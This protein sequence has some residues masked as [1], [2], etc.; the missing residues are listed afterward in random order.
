MTICCVASHGSTR[1]P[2]VLP[3]TPVDLVLVSPS[4]FPSSLK[5]RSPQVIASRSGWLRSPHL[6]TGGR[7]P[8]PQI[9]ARG[10]DKLEAATAYLARKLLRGWHVSET[11]A[12]YLRDSA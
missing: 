6:S 5:P 9:D 11:E 3:Q 7:A 2:P 12:L 10:G 1:R 8:W 4:R